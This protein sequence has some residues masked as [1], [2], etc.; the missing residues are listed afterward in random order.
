MNAKMLMMKDKAKLNPYFTFLMNYLIE[1]DQQ[2]LVIDEYMCSDTCP[3]LDS[4][5]PKSFN[6]ENMV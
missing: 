3:C 5:D 1:M 4:T 2:Q 6:G